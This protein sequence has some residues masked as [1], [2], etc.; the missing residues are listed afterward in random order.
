MHGRSG[1][2]FMMVD[3]ESDET[4]ENDKNDRGTFGG[5]IKLIMDVP[6]LEERRYG[7]RIGTTEIAVDDTYPLAE[8]KL[9]ISFLT[10]HI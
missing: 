9:L 4:W 5:M 2:V 8:S 6:A 7:I 3:H 1:P 10:F